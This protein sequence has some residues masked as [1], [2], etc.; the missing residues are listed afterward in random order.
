MR[1]LSRVLLAFLL[2]AV[3]C[4]AQPATNQ[5]LRQALVAM[6]AKVAELQ[7]QI[8]QMERLLGST[9]VSSPGVALP[10]TASGLAGVAPSASPAR[11]SSPTGVRG[12]VR[13][14]CAATTKKGTRCSRTASPG[15][16]YCWQH[17]GR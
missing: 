6:K 2:A 13:Q 11:S 8:D 15:S 16:A 9:A 10:S 7:A 3:A 12:A 17:G 1:S 4:A 5:Q 14:Q